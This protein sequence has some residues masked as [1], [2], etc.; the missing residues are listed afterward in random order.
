MGDKRI[1]DSK[2]QVFMSPVP[3]LPGH[4]RITE[5]HSTHQVAVSYNC[6][7]S[8]FQ[9]QETLLSPC[10]SRHQAG[11]AHTLASPQV[12]CQPRWFL[13]TLPT[14]SVIDPFMKPDLF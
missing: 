1:E 5:G 13:L 8:T 2:A 12:L 9:V 3:S 6:Y 7:N 10:H 11:M 14:S 4:K